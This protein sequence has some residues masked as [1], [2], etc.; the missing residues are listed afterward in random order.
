MGRKRRVYDN[1]LDRITRLFVRAHN[2]ELRGQTKLKHWKTTDY[3][4]GCFICGIKDVKLHRHRIIPGG[5]YT[6]ENTCIVC[7]SHHK[8]THKIIKEINAKDEQHYRMAIM[9]AKFDSRK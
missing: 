7:V 2:Q 6:D 9:L 1:E 5:L 3:S 8:L 4:V